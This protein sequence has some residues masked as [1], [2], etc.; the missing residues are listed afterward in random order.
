WSVRLVE[1]Y[2]LGEPLMAKDIFLMIKYAR[3]KGLLVQISTNAS[4]LKKY[5][6][7]VLDSDLSEM[8]VSVD[9]ATEETYKQYRIGGN[10]H[11]VIQGIKHFMDEKKRRGLKNPSVTFQFIVMK[12][13]EHEIEAVEKLAKN[14]GVDHL[15][16]KRVSMMD[17]RREKE[18][19]ESLKKRFLPTDQ[20]FIR[21]SFK[22]NKI[23][24]CRWAFSSQILQDGRVTSCCYD[25]DGKHVKGSAF[26]ESF[27]KIFRSREYTKMRKDIIAQKLDICKGCDYN[28][29][30]TEKVF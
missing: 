17:T 8:I 28:T 29:Q 21:D 26:E 12:H 23:D 7:Q 6:D 18:K 11:E 15:Q 9:G 5:T 14:L 22:Q 1:L 4:Y 24:P 16:L 2:L 30:V 27:K 20:R 3:S 13:N 10:F 19:Q 25:G